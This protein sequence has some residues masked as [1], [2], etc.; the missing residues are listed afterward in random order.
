[1]IFNVFS[2][3]CR[4]NF[5]VSVFDFLPNSTKLNFKQLIPKN[6]SIATG[7]KNEDMYQNL[8]T[9]NFLL[10]P[11]FLLRL[12]KTDI[13]FDSKDFEAISMLLMKP[14]AELRMHANL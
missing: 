5:F 14:R 8:R 6:L 1:L 9:N 13:A 10:L 12:A 11:E 2:I 7:S 4:L 3:G